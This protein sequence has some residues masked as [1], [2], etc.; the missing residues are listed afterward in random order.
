[1]MK[2]C[3]GNRV[4]PIL[5]VCFGSFWSLCGYLLSVC[6][7]HVVFVSL[8]VYFQLL[9]VSLVIFW[10]CV[11]ISLFII[12]YDCVSR[13]VIFK[14]NLPSLCIGFGYVSDCFL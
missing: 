14:V 5:C 12:F 11:L 8:G 1:M 10:N 13:F 9:Y 2:C 7:R 3:S 4:C 6:G